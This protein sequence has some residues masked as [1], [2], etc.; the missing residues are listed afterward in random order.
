M[1]INYRLRW[2]LMQSWQTHRLVYLVRIQEKMDTL[3]VMHH[4]Q[5]TVCLNDMATI[6]PQCPSTNERPAQF[7]HWLA[8]TLHTAH[9]TA[10]RT[11]HTAHRTPHTAHRTPHTAHRTPHTAHRTPHTAHRTPHTAHR[12]PHTAHRTPHTA[13]CTQ[14]TAHCTLHTA[15]TT[16]PK[17]LTQLARL[18]LK[19]ITQQC[20]MNNKANGNERPLRHTGAHGF[21]AR[22]NKLLRRRGVGCQSPGDGSKHRRFDGHVAS[23]E[24]KNAH[25]FFSY[26]LADQWRRAYPAIGQLMNFVIFAYIWW[27]KSTIAYIESSQTMQQMYVSECKALWTD[28]ALY[29]NILPYHNIMANTVL[30]WNPNH[31]Y[32]PVPTSPTFTSPP[33]SMSPPRSGI[34]ICHILLSH[35]DNDTEQM[36][37]SCYHMSMPAAHRL[38]I[39]PV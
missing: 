22:R 35:L 23:T 16:R 38:L 20:T 27:W 13:H 7:T 31:P 24:I 4:A 25:R 18:L 1:A 14:H 37:S 33:T 15:H 29:K 30:G 10:H 26:K 28:V 3:T 39:R 32:Y 17:V 8:C 21:V 19:P 12:T 6:L 36:S 11:P 34:D 9:H 5:H 2:A